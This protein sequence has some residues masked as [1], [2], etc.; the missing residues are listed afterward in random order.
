MVLQ[1]GFVTLFVTAFPLSPILALINNVIEL[2]L[3]AKKF[4]K[5]HQ[6]SVA[7]RAA[8]IG[9]W[10][11][12]IALISKISVVSNALI[13]ALTT[14][15]IPRMIYGWNHDSMDGFVQ[16]SISKYNISCFTQENDNVDNL[17]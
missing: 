6:R 2:R 11:D 3:D 7:H 1:Y 5:Y 10:E 8:T 15:A 9:A 13:I 12:Y 17:D 14:N 4:I 16:D